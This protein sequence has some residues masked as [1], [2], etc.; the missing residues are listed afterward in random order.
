MA[1][2]QMFIGIFEINYVVD[3]YLVVTQ[4]INLITIILYDINIINKHYYIITKF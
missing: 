4:E 2:K 1:K 3:L